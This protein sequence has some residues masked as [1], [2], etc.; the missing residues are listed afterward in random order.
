MSDEL[1]FTGTNVPAVIDEQE[2]QS[3][4]D[5]IALPDYEM[6]TE[7]KVL[8]SVKKAFRG[9][10]PEAFC[11]T[12]TRF[13]STEALAVYT[14]ST[15][16]DIK[17]VRKS[18]EASQ[19]AHKAAAMARFWYLGLT[20]DNAL[21]AGDYGT[22]AVS[23]LATALRKSVPYIYQ[24]RAVAARLS[25]VDC[26][27]LGVRG[28]DSTCLRK[29]AQVKDDCTRQQI[30]KAFIEHIKDTS[31]PDKLL[32][33]RK[34]FITAINAAM[35]MDAG[36]MAGSNPMEI[37]DSTEQEAAVSPEYAKVM[38]SLRMWEGYLKKFTN[39]KTVSELCDTAADFYLKDDVPDAQ[40]YLD[41]VTSM[42]DGLVT[43]LRVA[44]ANIKTMLEEMES[45][46]ECQLTTTN[47][48]DEEESDE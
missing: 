14:Q 37:G 30:A 4:Q 22:A 13:S 38:R 24:I 11:T 34:Q 36:D 16:E 46:A 23:Q 21:K 42:A 1:E 3:L 12:T 8:E 28:L 6:T 17:N 9:F 41:K 18:A 10:D 29:L 33:G 32:Q 5:V 31:D 2:D 19:L 15:M 48:D 45:L 43:A 7:Q 47:R 26:Y 40:T 35:T 27:L 25:V 39:E 44:S 20:I